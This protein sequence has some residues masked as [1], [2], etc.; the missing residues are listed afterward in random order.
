MVALLLLLPLSSK[1]FIFMLRTSSFKFILFNSLKI[2]AL[3]GDFTTNFLFLLCFSGVEGLLQVEHS[4]RFSPLFDF[5]ELYGVIRCLYVI[6]ILLYELHGEKRIITLIFF[7]RLC[8]YSTFEEGAT[9]LY[10]KFSHW[11]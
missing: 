3:V 1:V 9:N 4:L 10:L 7:Y 2:S 11:E 6:S 8:N 5:P